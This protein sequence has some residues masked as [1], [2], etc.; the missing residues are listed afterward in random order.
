MKRP[1]K[2]SIVVWAASV[3][4][5]VAYA[6]WAK[7]PQFYAIAALAG[8]NGVTGIIRYYLSNKK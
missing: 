2:I 7:K 5:A 8:A 3:L 6:Y 1:S 4:F